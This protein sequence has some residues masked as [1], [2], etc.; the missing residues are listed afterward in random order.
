MG[1]EEARAESLLPPKCMGRGWALPAARLL[2]PPKVDRTQGN[3]KDYDS[4]LGGGT[5]VNVRE[6]KKVTLM[7]SSTGSSPASNPM[8][9]LVP[10]TKYISV[11]K[12]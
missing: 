1:N 4:K 12:M 6:G 2:G 5:K 9:F 7:K 11:S 8:L 10:M 3:E